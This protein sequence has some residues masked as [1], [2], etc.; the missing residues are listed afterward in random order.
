MN[1]RNIRTLAGPLA[2]I[3]VGISGAI[4]TGG[5][6][7]TQLEI[8]RQRS[9]AEIEI[10]RT[11]AALRFM[12]IS[13]SDTSQ[14]HQALAIAAPILPPDIAFRLALEQFPHDTDALDILIRKYQD[15][16]NEYLIAS[17]EVPFH[18]LRQVIS[19]VPTSK[20][21]N[22]KE[23]H[24]KDLFQYLHAKGHAER[25]FD[26]ILSNDYQNEDFR[27]IALLFYFYNYREFLRSTVD[28]AVDDVYLR[29][30]FQPVL[31]SHMSNNALSM[32]A[33][34]AIAL[35]S[36][37]IFGRRYPS[38]DGDSYMEYAA[39]Y[40]W[41]SF[42]VAHGGIPAEPTIQS[43]IYTNVILSGEGL[44][45][46]KITELA[47]ESLRKKILKLDFGRLGMNDISLI[48]YA[49]AESPT[50]ARSSSYLLPDDV[51]KVVRTVLAWANTAQK[52]RELSMFFGS[53]SG[54]HLFRNLLPDCFDC[55][56]NLKKRERMARCTSARK[57]AEML[58]NWYGQYYDDSWYIPKFFHSV[59]VQ[60]P[61]LD[62]E[63]DH[64]KWGNW[65]GYEELEGD[66]D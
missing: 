50:V 41:N 60:F 30:R 6:N 53:L 66:C 16:A 21:P 52:R 34:R 17:L 32:E 18:E 58:A 54:E 20:K 2:A 57:F 4:L 24:A 36:S 63:I 51:V 27:I 7:K 12:E 13:E 44:K 42:D 43:Y 31:K 22:D 48:L 62:D 45:R 9:E 39:K 40:F 35:S 25:L 55:F 26:F 46:P 1:W 3:V 23:K 65:T 10:A 28:D 19:V 29:R 14:R 15:T 8:A 64:Q 47:S 11:N 61:D 49:Y 33:K 59:L 5:Y 38:S 37:L 56:T